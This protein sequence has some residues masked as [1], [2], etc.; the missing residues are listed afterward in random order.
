MGNERGSIPRG[1]ALGGPKTGGDGASERM[2]PTAPCETVPCGHR[3]WEDN[4]SG[5]PL[6]RLVPFVWNPATHRNPVQR[7]HREVLFRLLRRLEPELPKA[8]E[9]DDWDVTPIPRGMLPSVRKVVFFLAGFRRSSP[10]LL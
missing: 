1:E 9:G 8:I 2:A 6:A 7:T 10:L 5:V 3:L 4:E